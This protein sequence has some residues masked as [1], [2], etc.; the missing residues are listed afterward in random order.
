[1]RLQCLTTGDS[2]HVGKASARAPPIAFFANLECTDKVANVLTCLEVCIGTGTL[3]L[4]FAL[5]EGGLVFGC[6][7]LLAIAGWNEY[8]ALRIDA[9]RSW[10]GCDT[11][12]ATAERVLGPSARL[13][14]DLCTISTLLGEEYWAVGWG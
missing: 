11:Y 1:M 2:A 7:G 10:T 6:I 3:A 9:V 5:S 8:A 12:A 4:P 13:L 14:V